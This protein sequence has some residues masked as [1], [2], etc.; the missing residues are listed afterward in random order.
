MIFFLERLP[1]T[2][3][4]FISIS[5][6]PPSIQESTGAALELSHLHRTRSDVASSICCVNSPFFYLFIYLFFF[7]L[8][9]ADLLR[10]GP[11]PTEMAKTV[12]FWPTKQANT[13]R[14]RPIWPSSG[15][16]GCRN[17]LKWPLA[18]I[19]LLYVVMWE[20]KKKR[21]GRRRWEDTK[22]GLELKVVRKK[23][24]SI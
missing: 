2:S 20:T 23:N 22:K 17:R 8:K 19:L 1:L 9:L 5:I 21:E 24:K 15:R 18:A 16:F 4:P 7:T 3:P 13:A 12:W 6:L 10:L 14:F 11:I